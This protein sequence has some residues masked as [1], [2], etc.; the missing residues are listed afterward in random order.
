MP[1]LD[2]SL[3]T[4]RSPQSKRVG[5]EESRAVHD[6]G[7]TTPPPWRAALSRGRLGDPPDLFPMP[8]IPINTET[9]R[10]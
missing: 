6:G 1:I 3:W 10:K 7:G 5:P 2:D 9:S 4:K 8:K